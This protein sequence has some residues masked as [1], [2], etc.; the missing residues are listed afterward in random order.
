[1]FENIP[2][3]R[4]G[5]KP[6]P[7]HTNSATTAGQ[8]IDIRSDKKDIKLRDSLQQSIRSD[9][10]AL[11]DLLLWDEQ[12]L[13]FFE[14]VTYCP[15]YYLTREEIRLLGIHRIQIANRIQPGSMLIELGSGN[16]RKTRILL[17]ALEELGRPVDY[18][19]LD[20]SYPELERTL[21]PVTAGVYRHVRCFGLLGTYDDC[22]KWLDNADLQSRPKTILYLGSTLGNFEKGD[23]SQ[24]LSSFAQ[25]NCSFLLG[26]DGCKDEAKVL[27]AYN[28]IHGINHRFI[29][30]GL[31]RA[32]AILGHDMFDLETW[33]VAGRW[34]A[35]N[36][37]HNQY[38]Y[39][40]ADVSLDGNHIPA[41]RR[42]LA[43]RSHKYDADDREELYKKAG[44]SLVDSWS[45][46][47][48]GYNLV[49]L[50]KNGSDY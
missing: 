18:F 32:N 16:L 35:E 4:V 20:V 46:A 14:D 11:P 29:K 30:N 6:T 42:L 26:L 1:M 37:A 21:R 43:V 31:A 39:P 40:R 33:D 3:P 19:A 13:K 15:S 45:A 22:W 47:V 34:D 36:G 8:I 25:S 2:I 5:V 9:S 48:S 27:Q 24:F 38:Y 44:L 7:V 10:T 50:S 12:G 17:D 41:G 23:A 28:D 49:Y